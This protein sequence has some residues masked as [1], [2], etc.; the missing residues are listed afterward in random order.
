MTKGVRR[1]RDRLRLRRH[2]FGVATNSFLRAEYQQVSCDIDGRAGPYR[3]TGGGV[4][5][6]PAL[7][8]P[9]EMGAL[10]IA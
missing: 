8:S 10:G 3:S 5:F 2:C 7:V 9:V 6:G 4:D 1:C